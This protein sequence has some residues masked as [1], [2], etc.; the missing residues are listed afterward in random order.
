MKFKLC[1][2]VS[3]GF[4]LPVTEAVPKI[5]AAGFDGCF[6]GWSEQSDV[7]AWANAIAKEGLMYQSIHSP[8]GK[9]NTVWEEGEAGEA[10]TD[11][12]IK[13]LNDC[14]R[15]GVPVMVVHPII[16]MDRHDPTDLGI[17]RFSRLVEA[18]EKTDVKL[19]FENVE[20]A[21]YLAKIMSDLGYSDSVGFCWDTG[22]EMCYNYS[23]DMP[24]LYGD[25]LVATHFNDNLGMTDKSNM[26]WLDDA[27]LMPFDGIAD[28][29]G[30]MQRI[31]RHGY[32]GPLTFELTRNSKPGK[33]T[34]D[35][36]AELSYEQFLALAYEK[37]CKVAA[38]Y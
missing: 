12:L 2:D 7:D 5:K 21:E 9:I 20:G 11:M 14:H 15:C 23:N 32:S 16:G 35:I 10:Y 19:A 13:C 22:H 31:K 29:K 37:A 33:N 30:I 17:K 3:S 27:H 38:L 18:A 25:K 6:T 28:W 36:Y 8:F 26:T 4:T 24:A 1:I 34:H